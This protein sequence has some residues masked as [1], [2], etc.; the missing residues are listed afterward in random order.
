MLCVCSFFYL[1]SFGLFA[2]ENVV[3]LALFHFEAHLEQFWWANFFV[4]VVIVCL[5]PNNDGII[6]LFRFANVVTNCKLIITTNIQCLVILLTPFLMPKTKTPW[7]KN[8]KINQKR[9]ELKK[10]I[11]HIRNCLACLIFVL[12]TNWMGK[13]PINSLIRSNYETEIW[14][15]RC[16]ALQ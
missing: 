8:I 2:F 4:D 9:A 12:I 7:E 1:V 10:K 11:A 3:V 16:L 15:S 14:C 5:L 13:T 6:G